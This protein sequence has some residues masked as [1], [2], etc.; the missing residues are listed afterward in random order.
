[1]GHPGPLWNPVYKTSCAGFFV[2]LGGE[3]Y[4]G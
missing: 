1:M 3:I 4:V 2:C